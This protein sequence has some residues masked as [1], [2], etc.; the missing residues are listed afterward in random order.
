MRL[1]IYFSF[2]EVRLLALLFLLLGWAFGSAR[3][4]A[5]V[6]VGEIWRNLVMCSRGAP[7][8]ICGT[9]VACT[10]VLEET[11]LGKLPYPYALGDAA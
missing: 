10:G 9:V 8:F 11:T 7:M 2:V 5:E 6:G 1:E 3:R 4:P